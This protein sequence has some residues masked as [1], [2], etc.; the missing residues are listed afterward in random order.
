MQNVTNTDV[1]TSLDLNLFKTKEITS[2]TSEQ[3]HNGP[4]HLQQLSQSVMLFAL[5]TKKQSQDVPHERCR[6]HLVALFS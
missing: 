4:I 1:S 3:L 5:E 2:P 6:L